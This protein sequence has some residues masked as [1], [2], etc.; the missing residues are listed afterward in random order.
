V[1]EAV[2]K[3]RNNELLALQS[4]IS[5]EDNRAWVGRTALVLV[6]GKSRATARRAG[7]DGP[8]QLTGR[9]NCDR[10]VLFEGQ[11]RLIGEFVP[12]TVEDASAVALFGQ[13][14]TEERVGARGFEGS[15]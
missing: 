14:Q 6:E 2:K 3:R 10:I 15:P 9:T 4:A 11:D 1:P 13:V 5:L 12:V 8:D 7:W